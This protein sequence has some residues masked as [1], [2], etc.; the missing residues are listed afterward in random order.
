LPGGIYKIHNKK[1]RETPLPSVKLRGKILPI[2]L[3]LFSIFAV[4]LYAQE[5]VAKTEEVTLEEAPLVQEEDAPDE[6]TL[7]EQPL[8]V[9]GKIL[10]SPLSPE[11]Q[12][13]ELEIKSSTLPELAVWSRSLGLS[14]SGTR[15][16]ISRRIR[17]YFKIPQT[18]SQN[19]N[20][21]KIITI[22]SAQTTEYF[23]LEV[24]DEEYARLK[25]GV[26][27]RLVDGDSVHRIKAEE[28][29]FNRT[30]NMLTARGGVE[31]IK[32]KG[33]TIE[34]FRGEHIT[35][36]I[37]NWSSIFL[38]GVS[39][40]RIESDGT[41]YRFA[42]TVI[43]RD[44]DEDVMILN[45]AQITNAYNEEAL[46]S[47]SA[48]RLMLLPS[49]DFWIFNAVLKVGEIPVMYIP[50]FFFPADEVIFHPVIGYRSREGAFAQTTYYI[51]GRPTA[52][53]AD[54]S[55]LSRILGNSNDMEK[56][57]HGLFLRSTGNKIVNP[58]TTSLKAMLDYYTNLGIY[59]GIDFA[60]P[61]TGMLNP[62]NLSLGIGFTRTIS[63]EGGNYTI[64][65][66]N[67]DG[68]YE[69]NES[70]LFSH[71]VPY[72]YRMST[73]SSISG[74]YGSF[75]WNIPFYSDPY[76]NKDFLNRSE[77]MDWVNMIQQGSALDDEDNS[78]QSDIGSYNW[79]VNGNLRPSLP[80]LSPYVSDISF[81]NLSMALNFIQIRDNEIFAKNSNN[82]DRFFFAPDKYT[83]YSMSGQISGTPLSIGGA[84]QGTPTVS[85]RS[86]IEI[87]DPLKGIGIPRSPWPQEN[88][89][90]KQSTKDQLTPPALNQRF[91]IPAVGNLKFSVDYQLS[92][93]SSMELQ[94]MSG[95]NRWESAEQVNWGDVQSILSS[96]GGNG[97]VNF[98]FDHSLGVFTNT[99]TLSGSGTWRDYSYL[100]EEAEAY[101]TPQT[102]DGEIDENKL[103]TARRLQYSQTNYST[104]YTYN[105]AIRPLYNDPVFSQSN[106]QYTFRGT[107]VRSKRYIDGNGPELTPKWGAWVK[108]QTGDGKDIFGLNS[109]RFST[110]IAANV[111]NMQQ[112]ISFSTDLPP[113]DGLISTNGTFRFAYGTILTSE[114]N[115]NIQ[116]KKPEMINNEPNNEWKTD[117]FNFTETLRFGRI[118]SFAFKLILEPE[119]NNKITTISSSLT[120]WNFTMSFSAVKSRGYRFVPISSSNP[121][122]GGRWE[123]RN[124]E[125]SLYA[126][127]LTFSYN[128]AFSNIEIIKNRIN[129]S[130][131]LNTRLFFDLQRYTN[132]N[133]QFS[134]GFTLG[135]AGFLDLSFRAT[136]ENAAVFRYFKDVPGMGNLTSM[137]TDG[138]QNNLFIDLLDSFNFANE[139]KRRR[140]GFKMKTFNLTATHHL[141]DWRA[142]LN[143][144]MSPYLNDKSY[145]ARYEIN[146]DISFMVQWYVISEIKSDINY[147]T[148]TEKWTI[149]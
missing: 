79:Q 34:T 95:Y 13:V 16:E 7:D 39:E 47:I 30:R 84:N 129:F 77:N 133:F 134:M 5:A 80:V 121:S 112:S 82:P 141:G 11:Q 131:N 93:T 92:P 101:R 21:R 110:N 44:N 108:E 6:T 61:G 9:G 99:V 136:S 71:L 117:P 19:D 27:L 2:L 14:E 78:S 140:S 135:I 102:A 97:N 120:L 48:S 68:S 29:L 86:V 63:M 15:E 43:S 113:L 75:N 42:G 23:T 74:R 32:E 96:L 1:L 142:I 69:W 3:I 114:T 73:Q 50:F 20:S 143:I 146:A 88:N 57:R 41:T 89:G 55:S 137:Y 87:E 49:S 147:E 85:N 91:D 122:M 119:E 12:R 149:R 139:D 107:L 65:A 70:N 118:G 22:E 58:D 90:E 144:A 31:Y 76:V 46:W 130:L 28:V 67:Y 72:R 40:R 128:H 24:V 38:D 83:I 62:L 64:Y 145:P 124:E 116:F 8:A 66:P 37:D 53:P 103:E 109:H 36:N 123:Q 33:D 126:R 106:L 81:S 132:S 25:G 125:P 18:G 115:A 100:N 104:S 105:G 56:E 94:F 45:N 59:T 17:E 10:E 60:M 52:N 4:P 51:L 138:D 111:M 54:S 127:D 26:V 148:R 35:V 98:H